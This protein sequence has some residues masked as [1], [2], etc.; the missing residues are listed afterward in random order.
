MHKTKFRYDLYR[1]TSGKSGFVYSYAFLPVNISS[2]DKNGQ[3][4]SE[5]LI[6]LI[7]TG[8]NRSLVHGKIADKLAHSLTAP[9][10]IT[11]SAIGIANL[12]TQLY[13][14]TFNLE[15]LTPNKKNTILT[16]ENL[17]LRCHTYLQEMETNNS[18]KYNL[19]LLGTGDVLK[20][21]NI[22]FDFK[23]GDFFIQK[24]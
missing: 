13:I 15:I 22:T 14:H 3:K 12:E 18:E 17:P 4:H 19:M 9:E 1:F 16:L 7:D 2:F 8:A 6:A 21:F 23:D 10:V 24:H 5:E 11:D 20:Y